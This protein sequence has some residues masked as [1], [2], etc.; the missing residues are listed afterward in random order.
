MSGFGAA[1][2]GPGGALPTGLFGARTALELAEALGKVEGTGSTRSGVGATATTGAAPADGDG[3]ALPLGA[4][5]FP[6]R[7]VST[8]TSP[9]R[10]T[11]PTPRPTTS[12]V[13]DAGSAGSVAGAATVAF[14][15]E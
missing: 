1:A 7:I 6:P 11:A 5:S 15:L 4:G 2:L 12:R 13:L 9:V 3:P 8:K 14:E 10:S